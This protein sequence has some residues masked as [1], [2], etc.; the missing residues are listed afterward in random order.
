M[1]VVGMDLGQ[2]WL[3]GHPAWLR[4]EQECDAAIFGRRN[5]ME[6]RGQRDS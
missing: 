4:M 6:W 1:C 3:P 2:M 5:D